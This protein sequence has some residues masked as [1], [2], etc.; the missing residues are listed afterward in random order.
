MA[1]SGRFPGW[2]M[3]VPMQG[4]Q[5]GRPPAYPEEDHRARLVVL[6][7]HVDACYEGRRIVMIP[8]CELRS[9]L[10]RMVSQRADLRAQA[11]TLR[12]SLE[13]LTM[14][15]E[16]H[17]TD[18]CQMRRRVDQLEILMIVVDREARMSQA[19]CHAVQRLMLLNPLGVIN[20]P[21]P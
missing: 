8:E 15:W 14:G 18:E 2:R 17:N 11:G 12:S 20:G 21:F 13:G 16:P 5:Q 7:D 3:P 10:P 6:G 9:L 1:G 19:I 4:W